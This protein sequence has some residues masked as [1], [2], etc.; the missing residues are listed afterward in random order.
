MIHDMVG[1]HNPSV[2]PLTNASIGEIQGDLKLCE[3]IDFGSYPTW[4]RSERDPVYIQLQLGPSPTV[5]FSS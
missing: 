4:A 1:R 5:R 2:Q 3:T